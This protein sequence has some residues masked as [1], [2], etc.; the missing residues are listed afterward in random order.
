MDEIRSAGGS[1]S[2]LHLLRIDLDGEA[3]DGISHDPRRPDEL[4]NRHDVG[5]IDAHGGETTA[6]EIREIELGECVRFRSLSR[7]RIPEHDEPSQ[8]ECQTRD[9]L[10]ASLPKIFHSSHDDPPSVSPTGDGTT[11]L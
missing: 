7:P 2:E 5:R 8:E 6:L 4:G 10:P 3:H 1:P 11:R 9:S